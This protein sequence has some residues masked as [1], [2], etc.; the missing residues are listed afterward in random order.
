[1]ASFRCQH[2]VSSKCAGLRRVRSLSPVPF[3][4]GSHVVTRALA[5][6]FFCARAVCECGAYDTTP[7]VR[8]RHGRHTKA[9][10]CHDP[11]GRGMV[12]LLATCASSMASCSSSLACFCCSALSFLSLLPLKS[13]TSA[14]SLRG[15]RGWPGQDA[16]ATGSTGERSGTG[17][18]SAGLGREVAGRTVE[19]RH[20]A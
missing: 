17:Q 19:E 20:R 5:G 10:G 16:R 1:M 18:E 3:L 15:P 4:V 2:S 11:P 13:Q 9:Q 7:C 14:S 12:G 6:S 8:Q